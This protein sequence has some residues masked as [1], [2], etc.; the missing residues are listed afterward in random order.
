MKRIIL[1]AT[2]ALSLA[3]CAGTL[4]TLNLASSVNLNT[5]EGVVAGYG[6]AVNQ[7]RLYKAQPL[8][9]TGT[10]LSITNIC[11]KRS[12]IVR[13]QAAD[14]IANA[15]VNQ[16]VLFSK[17]NPTVDPSQYILAASQALTSLQNV[18]NIANSGG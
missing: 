17:N 15:A 2:L 8:C 16:A 13:L 18:V 7:E 9:K 10:S 12:T 14:K 1:V 5:L 11:A 6:I 4:P 3:G